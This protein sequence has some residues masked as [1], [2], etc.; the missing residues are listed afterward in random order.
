MMTQLSKVAERKPVLPDLAP[1]AEP[2]RLRD[3]PARQRPRELV[4][5]F[6]VKAVQDEVLL[7]ILL[8]SGVRGTNVIELARRLLARY[9]GALTALARATVDELVALRVPGLGRVKAQVLKAALELAT[10]MADETTGARL[11][12]RSPEDAVRLLHDR[13]RTL[14]QEVFW[15]LLLDTRNGLKCPPVTI[16]QGLLD[17]SLVHAREVF[18]DAIRTAS[19]GV[20]LAHNHPSGD[21]APSAE[22]VRITRRIVEAGRVID[23]RV[24]DHVVLGRPDMPGGKGFVSM[25][26]AGILEFV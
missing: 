25:R 15:V 16:S 3:L 2:Y 10:R 9:D 5:R 20:V 12:I 6:G 13:V 4:D 19:A 8:R 21:P 11:T 23:I 18:R 17:A 14:E 24:L 26:E 7:A 22:D 1:A